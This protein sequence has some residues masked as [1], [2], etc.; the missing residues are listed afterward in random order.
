MTP[1]MVAIVIKLSFRNPILFCNLSKCNALTL[2][3][4]RGKNGTTGK[5]AKFKLLF[6]VSWCTGR[7]CRNFGAWA[8]S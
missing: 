2:S 6:R 1:V 5:L 3:Q 8:M 7:S 4:R